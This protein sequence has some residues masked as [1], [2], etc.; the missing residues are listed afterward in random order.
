VVKASSEL[1]QEKEES[2][3][4]DPL[5]R[6]M[7]SKA[8]YQVAEAQ[9]FLYKTGKRRHL[10]NLSPEGLSCFRRAAHAIW[11]KLGETLP[12]TRNV[13]NEA[14]KACVEELGA[15]S[16]EWFYWGSVEGVT[17]RAKR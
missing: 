2:K 6:A 10:R 11:L 1:L 17:H 8:L 7:L 4:I 12:C 14:V 15:C 16:V 3:R 5:N 13:G 9:V